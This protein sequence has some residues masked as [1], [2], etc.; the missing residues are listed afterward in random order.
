MFRTQYAD[1]FSSRLITVFEIGIRVR[2]NHFHDTY[3][4][5]E[6]FYRVPT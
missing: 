4:F 1:P 5:K 3:Y 2:T 6:I